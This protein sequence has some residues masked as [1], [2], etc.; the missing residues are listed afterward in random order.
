MAAV[1]G[2]VFWSNVLQELLG[3][4]VS[5]GEQLAALQRAQ[6]V[7]ERGQVPELGTEYAF[8]SSLVRDLACDSLLSAQ[9]IAYSRQVA[10]HLARLFGKE[11]LAQYYGVVAYQYQCAQEPRRELFY[12]LSAAEH[13]QGIYANV[14]ALRY[15]ARALELLGELEAED[16]DSR[17]GLWQDWR[18]ESLKGLGKVSFGMGR[19]DE[20]EPYLRQAVA[21][22][23]EVEAPL[24]ELI[25]LYYWLCEVLFWQGQL[26]EQIQI[27]RKGLSLLG[28]NLE[29]VEAALM[30]QEIAVGHRASGDAAQFAEFTLRTAQFLERLP[31][32]EELR[33]AYDHVVSM[34]LY[35]RK[36]I[37]EAKRWL[38]IMEGRAAAH[39][40]VRALA[41]V[42]GHAGQVLERTGDLV[43][44]V[45]RYRQALERYERI[46][47]AKQARE[48]LENT[49][50]ALL[51][52]GELEQAQRCVD[53]ALELE[54]VPGIK[55]G[56]GWP[57]LYRGRI[58]IAR[59]DWPEALRSVEKA[60]ELFE[61][62]GKGML[63]AVSRY[64]LARVH[65][66]RGDRETALRCLQEATLRAG[67]ES[68]RDVPLALAGVLTAV[69]RAV[70]GE[71]AFQAF[72]REW[73]EQLPGVPLVQWFLEPAEPGAQEDLPFYDDRFAGSL[74][75]GWAWQ[76]PL[77]D[78]VLR[79]QDGLQIHATNGRDLWHV[80]L[81][82]PRV[83]RQAAGPW[84][85]EA[86]C[87]PVCVEQPAIGGCLVWKDKRNYLRLDYGSGG[88]RCVMLL[89]CLDNRDVV[90]GRGLLPTGDDEPVYLR[91]ER[92][93]DTVRGLVS[94]DGQ[95][96]LTLGQTAF[97]LEGDSQVG[98]YAAGNIDRVSYPG[99]HR[100]GT[101]IRF[102]R[103]R[104][105]RGAG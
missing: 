79:V 74:A 91:L 95:S 40:D 45:S 21:L 39:Y 22:A 9:R 61:E 77:D 81:S 56:P 58:L 34:Y 3:Q 36:D 48:V 23:E 18:L 88:E 16:Q 72:C 98:L 30:N 20:A 8:R 62:A 5:L 90:I 17:G 60:V 24:G 38:E 64:Y 97:P 53:R 1:I 84:M 33:P 15:Y 13:A 31:Y 35:D 67:P 10:D 66:R 94:A 73:H 44:A 28:D 2:V 78:C 103:F 51:G 83:V 11:V 41:E 19:V 101:A 63:V 50:E 32:S 46:G 87:E 55:G 14:E 85:A 29:S 105:W 92:S 100:E 80:N 57:Y 76:D 42:H 86:I 7:V 68:L 47:D 104:L 25:R 12:T 27:A 93:G 70:D 75:S 26:E 71:G 82:A 54:V 37:D 4:D 6:F 43:G 96:W 89:G 52:V 99:A 102:A 65:L 59:G 69:E 49:A